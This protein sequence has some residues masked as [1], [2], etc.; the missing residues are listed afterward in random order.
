MS[1]E[2]DA[3]T[4][5]MCR[6][7]SRR[8]MPLMLAMLLFV[9]YIATQA[10]L[11][12]QATRQPYGSLGIRKLSGIPGNEVIRKLGGISGNE[13][14]EEKSENAISKPLKAFLVIL[15]PTGPKYLW[16]RNTLRQTWFKLA[17]DNVLQRFV[18]GMKSLDKEATDELIQENKEHGDL[19][20]LWDFNDSY[21]GLAAK[22]LL[23][24]KWLDENL[25]FKYV[26][27]TDDDTFVRTELL[28]KELKER[29][30]QSKLFWGFFSGKSPVYREGIYEEKD[31]FLCDTYLPYAF[32]GGYIL[33]ADLAH[34]IASNA[35]WLKPYKSEDVSMGA[36][37][38]PLDVFRVHD[39]RFNSEHESRGCMDEYLINHKVYDEGMKAQYKMV[40]ETGRLCPKEVLKRRS[41]IYN[42]DVPPS[43]CCNRTWGI[44]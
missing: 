6:R 2:V 19:V 35:H 32:G 20:F 44:I 21:G 26:L 1:T 16:R 36:W 8:L 15:I 17:D 31:W 11:K 9:L 37:L 13:A 10:V 25:D 30:I 34:F 28:Q 4:V 39:P 3:T 5:S 40:I 42:W 14:I 27:K 12:C 23:T 38:S 24:F 43:Q 18:I 41:Y 29:N 22:V 33:S 7:L